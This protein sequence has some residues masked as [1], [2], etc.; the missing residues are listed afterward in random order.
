MNVRM[1]ILLRSLE[2]REALVGEYAGGCARA[3]L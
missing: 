1:K 2:G 3:C